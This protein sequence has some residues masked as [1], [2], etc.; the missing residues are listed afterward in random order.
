MVE[1]PAEAMA[2]LSLL[3]EGALVRAILDNIA[4]AL[5]TFD[6]AGR[7]AACNPAA[8]RLFG[9]RAS[10]VIGQ[11]LAMLLS[12]AYPGEPVL[13]MV[14]PQ[15]SNA[16]GRRSGADRNA[17]FRHDRTC[18][19]RDGSLFPAELHVGAMPLSEVLWYVASVRDI[20]EQRATE[21]ALAQQSA[22]LREQA[23]LIDLAHDAIITCDLL[24]L[25]ATWNPAAALYGWSSDEA[26][27]HA[28]HDLLH[29]RYPES[30]EGALQQLL[31]TSRWEGELRQRRRDGSEV[32][33]ASRWA[34]RRD[35]QGEPSGI[36]LANRA[37]TAP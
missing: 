10:E 2:E 8:E 12:E 31:R 27:D 33:V 9:Y 30:A 36:A 20:S 17:G 21:V 24:G 35:A 22:R 29:T 19:R 6:E 13:G 15:Q 1:L 18:R 14:R 5:L 11:P 4:E 7:V 37:I 23:Q 16:P 34:L 25:I 3:E 32:V 26:R 28:I